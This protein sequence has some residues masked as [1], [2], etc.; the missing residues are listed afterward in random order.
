MELFKETIAQVRDFVARTGPRRP[1]DVDITNVW[2]KG[3][4]RNIVLKEDLGLELGSPEMDS[5]SCLLWTHDLPLVEDGRITLIGDDFPDKTGSSLPFGKVVIAG[6]E[7]FSEDNAY[8]RHK[9]M[10]FLR[11]NLDLKGFMLRAVSQFMREW[12]RI[13]KEA[14]RANFN[15]QVLG[16]ALIGLF[17]TQPFVKTVEI[18]YCTSSTA[19][20]S[21]L[22]E[23]T[24]PAEKIIAAMNK[25][26]GEMDFECETCD[27]QAVCDDA[28]QL[29]SMRDSLMKKSK[30]AGHG[31]D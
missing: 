24:S 2:P 5:V 1:W 7:G 16:S 18:I 4:G 30:E 3:G 17:R 8:D 21:R 15:A 12:C 27:Y 22:K 26:A 19:D 29:K 13:S 9:E 20:V 10:D 31:R 25:M 11:Y 23:I 28:T 6:V 14:L